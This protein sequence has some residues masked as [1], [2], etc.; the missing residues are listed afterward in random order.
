MEWINDHV[1]NLAKTLALPEQ[2]TISP[3]AEAAFQAALDQ[4]NTYRGDPRIFEAVLQAFQQT[5]CLPL[6]LAG[7][8]YVHTLG[9]YQQG[10]AFDS[11]GLAMARKWLHQAEQ[12]APNHPDVLAVRAQIE[13]ADL[14]PD[15][16]QNTLARICEISPDHYLASLTALDVAIRSGQADAFS[17]AL[18]QAQKLANNNTRRNTVLRRAAWYYMRNGSAKQCIQT[19]T[20]IAQLDPNDPWNW[21]NL[22]LVH[23][24]R[25]NLLGAWRCNAQALKL[26]P[27]EA[28]LAARKQIRRKVLDLVGGIA[29]LLGIVGAYI[30]FGR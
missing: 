1:E 9:A 10:E 27:F 23:L 19:M 15:T 22:S 21:H 25:Y 26:M 6:C 16:A 3:Q 12:Y 2:T 8:A 11:Q 18:A 13:L 5:N 29:L 17:V 24:A 14:Q 20:E 7:I 28:A 4:A 30:A